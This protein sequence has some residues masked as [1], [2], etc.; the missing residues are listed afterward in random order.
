MFKIMR[1]QKGKHTKNL[2]KRN[3][4]SEFQKT[5]KVKK[6]VT[7]HNNNTELSS[8]ISR[9]KKRHWTPGSLPVQSQIV[10][11]VQET[12]NLQETS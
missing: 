8:V 6:K 3:M 10:P 12:S 5:N 1:D 9:E 2:D 7:N 11:K 4:K